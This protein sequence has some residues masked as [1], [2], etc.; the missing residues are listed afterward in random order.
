[1]TTILSIRTTGKN[2][3]KD[4]ALALKRTELFKKIK[5]EMEDIKHESRIKHFKN[6]VLWGIKSNE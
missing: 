3:K 6:E 1:M 5:A 2:L 4:V